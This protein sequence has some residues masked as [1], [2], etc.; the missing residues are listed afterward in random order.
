MIPAWCAVRRT[1]QSRFADALEQLGGPGVGEELGQLVRAK[2][3][4]PP[5]GCGARPKPRPTALA[6]ASARPDTVP[7]AVRR[8]RGARGNCRR[9]G[10]QRPKTAD[11]VVLYLRAPSPPRRSLRRFSPGADGASVTALQSPPHLLTTLFPAPAGGGRRVRPDMLWGSTSWR[12]SSRGRART[13]SGGARTRTPGRVH[14]GTETG[15]SGFGAEFDPDR[16]PSLVSHRRRTPAG[17]CRRRRPPTAADAW[18]TPSPRPSSGARR[19]P[20][21]AAWMP[22]SA[23]T[24]A[25]PNSGALRRLDTGEDLGSSGFPGLA[26]GARDRGQARPFRGGGPRRRPRHLPPAT[27]ARPRQRVR[28]GRPRRARP[29]RRRDR[30]A[31]L[32]GRGMRRSKGERA[33]PTSTPRSTATG[34]SSPSAAG[35]PKQEGERK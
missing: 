24:P 17:G 15:P 1:F 8:W 14:P 5:A 12:S 31:P 9:S 29:P 33:G 23:R 32:H 10:M 30:R 4:I 7:G 34:C 35:R 2:P 19:R 25:E 22:P 3:G 21:A 26:R 18:S 27:T 16:R 6:A 20:R 11:L 28:G 13:W